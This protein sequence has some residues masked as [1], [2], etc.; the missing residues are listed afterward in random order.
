M[1]S[2]LVRRDGRYSLQ[3]RQSRFLQK[4]TGKPLYR[5]SLGTSDYRVAQ[6]RLVECLR[7]YWK[8]NRS[9][10][11]EESPEEIATMKRLDRNLPFEETPEEIAEMKSGMESLQWLDS[12]RETLLDYLQ[13]DW[14]INDDRLLARQKFE[15]FIESIVHPPAVNSE[16]LAR[17]A[18]AELLMNEELARFHQ[19]NRDAATFSHKR[20]LTLA[21]EQG[22]FDGSNADLF[23]PPSS[24]G[25]TRTQRESVSTDR[26]ARRSSHDVLGIEKE[27]LV[28]P[29]LS[30]ALAKFA[31]DHRMAGKKEDALSA[32]QLV[33]NFMIDE[34]SDPKVS[35][36]TAEMTA[37]LN[38]MLVD[39]PDR[40]NI[41][42]E[43]CVSLSSRYRYAAAHGWTDLKR[44]TEARIRNGYHASLSKFF[45]WLIERR[46]FRLP[47]P[48][49]NYISPEN[50]VSLP[51]DAFRTEELEEIISQ[52]LF[53]GCD[54]KDR[55][56]KPG[57]FFV[58]SHLYWAYVLLLL[59]GL[60]PGE[61]GQLEVDDFTLRDGIWYLNLRGFDP[62]KGRVAK[63]DV[64]RFKTKSSE[65]TVPLHP[66]ILDLGLLDRLD[67]LREI[68]CKFAFPEWEPYPKPGGALRWGQPITKSWQYLKTKTSI[69]RADVTLYSTR[70]WF[71]ELLD[72]TEIKD[73]A[74]KR[75]MGHVNSKDVPSRYG[76]KDR[77]TL[78]DLKE[79]HKAQSPVID[80]MT[81]V[82]MNAKERAERGELTTL[83]PWLTASNW[84]EH[85]RERMA[86][87][88][89]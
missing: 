29:L 84:S 83:K 53:T 86:D 35:E 18:F 77:L 54:G 45:D 14:P 75:L 21:Y 57:R 16:T 1:P 44:L 37:S 38:K 31:E 25:S 10:P 47:K 71:A 63:K 79:I 70:H 50:L 62:S 68:G 3:V 89:D 41:P 78:R 59:T 74:R 48:V 60:R 85:Y 72:N 17:G 81:E 12:L 40:P 56:W 8:M 55:I 49:F 87:K 26:L 58:Q 33:V 2:Y 66:L 6:L 67:E 73:R 51:R 13:D 20:A 4:L 36:I 80:M 46:Y 15:A 5:V 69:T 76:A 11:F 64:R 7:W 9:L 82:L 65:R 19:Q 88:R 52:P 61:L 34:F 42:K 24:F 39:I 28:S 22:R 43:E 32:I 27:G 23:S 30:E